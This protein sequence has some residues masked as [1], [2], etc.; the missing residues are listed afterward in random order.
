MQDARERGKERRDSGAEM[1]LR[2]SPTSGDN[3]HCDRI[4][5]PR[6]HAHV[7]FSCVTP[8]TK[9]VA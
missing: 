7:L 2:C 8:G 6:E 9:R 5:K 1:L 4:L 3:T